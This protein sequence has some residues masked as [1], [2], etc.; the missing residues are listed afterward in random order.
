MPSGCQCTDTQICA[1][2]QH[3]LAL[4]HSDGQGAQRPTV[5]ALPLP[6]RGR[7]TAPQYDSKLEERYAD[8]LAVRQRAGEVHQWWYEPIGL[9]LG[10]KCYYH[11]DFL[12]QLSDG[13]LQIHEI[14]G[15]YI[16]EDSWIKLK[17]AA[18]QYPCFIFIMIKEGKNNG[19]NF[20]NIE[21]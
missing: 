2:C 19:W 8:H 6:A 5:P 1:R 3:Y 21:I 20:I 16:R 17:T 9:R 10:Q 12:V 14:K 7:I 13:V 4:P 18:K 11:P 15:A